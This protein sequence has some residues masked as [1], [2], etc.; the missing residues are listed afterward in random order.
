MVQTCSNADLNEFVTN[1]GGWGTQNPESAMQEYDRE[2]GFC[3][4]NEACRRVFATVRYCSPH[5]P[6][7]DCTV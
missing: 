4:E 5:T 1:N 2:R 7:I 6:E 3:S